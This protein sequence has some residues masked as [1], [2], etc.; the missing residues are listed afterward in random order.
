MFDE[1]FK[2]S[3]TSLWDKINSDSNYVYEGVNVT[4]DPRTVR[5]F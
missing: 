1:K 3:M 2:T 4:V 5:K